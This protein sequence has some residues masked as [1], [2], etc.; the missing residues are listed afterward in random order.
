MTTSPV[1]PKMRKNAFTLIELLITV[2]LIGLLFTIGI[3]YYQNFS[4]QQIVIQAA[5]E[6]KNNL[7][8]A[9]SKALA[10]EKDCSDSA[11][12]GTGGECTLD[13]KTLDGWFVDISLDLDSYEIY[14]S[15][16]GTE[17]SSKTVQLSPTVTLQAFDGT[18]SPITNFFFQPLSRGVSRDLV[19]F[20]ISGYGKTY[21]MTLTKAGEIEDVGFPAGPTPTP[22]IALTPTPT[23]TCVPYGGSC[24]FDGQ[25]CSPCYCHSVQNR[26]A[27]GC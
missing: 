7:R 12:E 17:F 22:T 2:S 20:E 1:S 11:C 13:S 23:P 18:G 24:E 10:G 26:C 9:Q 16:E 8:H 3:A 27:G 14:G 6:F 5:K 19:D 15:C 25:C 21:E 4:R